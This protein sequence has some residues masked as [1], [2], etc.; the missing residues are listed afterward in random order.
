MRGKNT[1]PLSIDFCGCPQCF[2]SQVFTVKFSWWNH[3]SANTQDRYSRVALLVC[4]LP[5]DEISEWCQK[6]SGATVEDIFHQLWMLWF[7]LLPGWLSYWATSD[8]IWISTMFPLVSF[9][10]GSGLPR[11][12]FVFG[13]GVLVVKLENTRMILCSQ[14][15]KT[16]KSLYV[17][18]A[19][20]VK[21]T[22]GA[23]LGQD[24]V[25]GTSSCCI[26]RFWWKKSKKSYIFHLYFFLYFFCIFNDFHVNSLSLTQSSS[27][28]WHLRLCVCSAI[29]IPYPHKPPQVWVHK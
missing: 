18:L 26:F 5:S 6:D 12:H 15:Q 21:C 2:L 25:E 11:I 16:M 23:V 13:H 1:G 14:V 17:W 28:I 19:F 7:K 8:I 22:L 10:A 24:C 27:N 3:S 20:N 4:S 9:C 29:S